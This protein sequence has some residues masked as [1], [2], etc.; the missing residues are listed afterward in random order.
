MAKKAERASLSLS[1]FF[2]GN[3]RR[4]EAAAAAVVEAKNRNSSKSL[5][6]VSPDEVKLHCARKSRREAVEDFCALG[7]EFVLEGKFADLAAGAGNP[8]QSIAAAAAAECVRTR[9]LL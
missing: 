7:Q 9:T 8:A 2:S 1:L 6:E 5:I 3:R 4:S